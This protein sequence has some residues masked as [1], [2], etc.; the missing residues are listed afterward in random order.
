M[1]RNP[2]MASISATV[3]P[4]QKELIEKLAQRYQTSVSKYFELR[5]IAL[6]A[7]AEGIAVP[8]VPAQVR[9]AP[10]PVEAQAIAEA[11]AP[12]LVPMVRDEVRAEL[13]RQLG[14]SA[15]QPAAGESGE[16]RKV[17]T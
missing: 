7:K 14:Q 5:A 6:I 16:R 4:Q 8:V 15:E 3:W 13:E 1:S 17:G 12:L 9:A 10:A 2:Q 11:I